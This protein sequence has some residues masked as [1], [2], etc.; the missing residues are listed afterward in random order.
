MATSDTTDMTSL[1]ALSREGD[2]AALDAL[3]HAIQPTIYKLAQRF[4]MIPVDAEDA[5]QEILLKIIT[6]L[7]QFDGRSQFKTWAYAVASNHLLDLKRRPSEQE[8][9]FD[10]FAEDL[11]QGLSETP[12]EGPDTVVLLEEVRIGCTLAMLQCLDRD[13]RL[14]YTLGE[15]LD[16]EHG[17]AAEVLGI[18]ASA[19]RKRLSRARSI[20]TAFMLGQC[21]LVNPDN[22]CRC[23]KRVTQAQA[24]GR[25]DPKKLIFSTSVERAQQFPEVLSEIRQ[26]EE[27]QRAAALYRAQMQPEVSQS[28]THWL[29]TTLE[30]QEQRRL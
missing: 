9:S 29:K 20:V 11:S 30:H 26:L 21:G 14:A 2:R 22:H 25:V 19:Y 13:A 4:L 18:S 8:M 12:I 27:N 16:L 1:V 28:F 23:S 17:E 15:I 3:I 7:S 10:E 6:R 5:T 24:L